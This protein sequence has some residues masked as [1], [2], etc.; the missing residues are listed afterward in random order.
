MDLS[1]R[2]AQ[3]HEERLPFVRATV[4]R[5]QAPTSAHSGD[6]AL[7]LVDG[8]IEGFVGGQCTETSVRAAAQQALDRGEGVLL[9]VLP[10]ESE[11]FPETPGATIA[12]NPCMSGGA[13]E[14][15]LEPQL[16]PTL[17]AVSGT[18]PIAQAVADFARRVDYLVEQVNGS[19]IPAGASAVIIAT[20]GGDEAAMIRAALDA[21]VGYVGL[22]ASP[23]RGRSVLEGIVS[24]TEELAR[25]HTPAGLDVGA[26]TAAEIGLSIVVDIVRAVR[27]GELSRTPRVSRPVSRTA[28]DPVCGMTVTVTE[29]TPHLVVAGADAWFCCPGCRRAYQK[30]HAA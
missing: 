12:V 1:I 8:T 19:D 2:E 11:D 23:R 6:S 3:L 20:H 9:R 21:G 15:F 22:V 7:V 17:V 10:A 4:V 16:P 24:S 28:V 14:I 13:M 30:E 29:S 25:V 26:R 5:A 18:S 27:S